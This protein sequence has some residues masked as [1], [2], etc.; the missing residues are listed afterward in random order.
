MCIWA[1]GVTFGIIT[2]FVTLIFKLDNGFVKLFLGMVKN[3]RIKHKQ[4]K[5]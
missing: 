2:L 1:V 5:H 4:L 3:K